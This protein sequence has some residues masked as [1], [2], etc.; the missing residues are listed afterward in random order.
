MVDIAAKKSHILVTVMAVRLVALAFGYRAGN[1]DTLKV[2]SPFIN[3]SSIRIRGIP[4]IVPS[5]WRGEDFVSYT[6]YLSYLVSV[7]EFYPP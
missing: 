7:I 4:G 3:L 2:E 6:K 5:A 1:P